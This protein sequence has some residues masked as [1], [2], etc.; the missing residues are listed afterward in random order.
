MITAF[1]NAFDQMNSQVSAQ[2][3][4]S[5]PSASVAS[6]QLP[7]TKLRKISTT[8][9]SGFCASE[10]GDDLPISIKNLFDRHAFYDGPSS[11]T[12]T[13]LIKQMIQ[14]QRAVDDSEFRQLMNSPV[15]HT[16]AKSEA[17]TAGDIGIIR[18]HLDDG[19]YRE[20]SAF[21]RIA[22]DMVFTRDDSSRNSPYALESMN[23]VLSSQHLDKLPSRC[24]DDDASNN[25]GCPIELSYKRCSSLQNYREQHPLKAELAQLR[26]VLDQVLLLEKKIEPYTLAS[27]AKSDDNFDE[28]LTAH[29][30]NFDA[31]NDATSSLLKTNDPSDPAWFYAGQ[32][33]SILVALA[34]QIS[35]IAVQKGDPMIGVTKLYA[36][37]PWQGVRLGT[38]IPT[39]PDG[40]VTSYL[41]C[42]PFARDANCPAH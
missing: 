5:G 33:R 1:V 4:L 25:S 7:S 42:A 30:A 27:Q 35:G 10:I 38:Q 32:T 19:R 39:G 24:R 2:N 36:H 13:L 8:L 31:F 9:S 29:S 20:Q 12:S 15:C 21:V 17:P 16:L 6:S 28:V 3:G 41:L 14:T 40:P 37:E 18:F 34:V 11:W 22:P 23:Y 26:K